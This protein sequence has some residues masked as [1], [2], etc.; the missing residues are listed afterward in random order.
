ML[1]YYV[2]DN[3]VLSIYYDNYII[4]ELEDC[5]NMTEEEIERLVDEV[6][7]ESFF[8]NDFIKGGGII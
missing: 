1:N 7:E 2:D 3:G 6:Y 5:G 4:A 8:Y